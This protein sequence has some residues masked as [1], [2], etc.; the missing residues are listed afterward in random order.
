MYSVSF[1]STSIVSSSIL[2]VLFEKTCLITVFMTTPLFLASYYN[3]EFS[4]GG[5]SNCDALVN[6]TP[7][8]K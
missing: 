4:N 8:I 1:V 5:L 7:F 6:V 3:C 2:F